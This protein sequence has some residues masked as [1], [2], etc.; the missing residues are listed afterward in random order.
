MSVAV[1]GATPVAFGRYLL[2]AKLA[3]G[4]MGEVF[5]ARVEGAAGFEKRVVI[6]RILPHLAESASLSS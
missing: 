3:S 5:L 6:K 2:E 4:G 1:S